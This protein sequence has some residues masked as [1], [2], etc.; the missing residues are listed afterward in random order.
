MKISLVILNLKFNGVV[1]E[2]KKTDPVF[3]FI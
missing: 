2:K 1:L 3:N